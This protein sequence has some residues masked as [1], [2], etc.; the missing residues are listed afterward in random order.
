[1]RAPSFELFD[2]EGGAVILTGLF[3]E[4]EVVAGHIV[5]DPFDPAAVNPNSYNYRLGPLLKRYDETT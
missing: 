1:M 3:I 2:P 4:E 5:I